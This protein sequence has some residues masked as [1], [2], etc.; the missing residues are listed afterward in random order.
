MSSYMCSHICV[1]I[2]EYQYKTIHICVVIYVYPYMSSNARQHICAKIY[3]TSWYDIRASGDT[4]LSPP[5]LRGEQVFGRR[6]VQVTSRDVGTRFFLFREAM[7]P[8]SR[9][10]AFIILRQVR[11]LNHHPIIDPDVFVSSCFRTRSIAFFIFTLCAASGAH[12][13]CM[14]MCPAHFNCSG[15]CRLP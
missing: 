1:S 5:S 7:V 14:N 9:C 13:S 6:F 11:T 8:S 12:V 2:Y 4:N 10:T 15:M 3:V